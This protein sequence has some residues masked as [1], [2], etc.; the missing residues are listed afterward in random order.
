MNALTAEF[1]LDLIGGA[2]VA[3]SSVVLIYLS[4][5]MRGMRSPFSPGVNTAMVGVAS[6]TFGLGL[7]FVIG[8]FT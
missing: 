4:H 2:L 8:T 7:A 6:G 3:L 5:V 1:F